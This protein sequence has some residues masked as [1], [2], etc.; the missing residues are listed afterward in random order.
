MTASIIF[1]TPLFLK[2]VPQITG[3]NSTL[4]VPLRIAFLISSFVTC[5]PSRYFSMSFSSNSATASMSSIRFSSAIALKYAGMSISL[6]SSAISPSYSDAVM[7][8]KSM[9]PVNS[10]SAPIGH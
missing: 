8:T 6:D 2:D 1:F 4:S 5:S 10:A 9:I 3:K 7:V